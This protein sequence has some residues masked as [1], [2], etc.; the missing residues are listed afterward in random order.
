MH[1]VILFSIHSQLCQEIGDTISQPLDL[2][3]SLLTQTAA[4]R[5]FQPLESTS[6]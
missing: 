2:P 4:L 6:S 1:I 5:S 3:E